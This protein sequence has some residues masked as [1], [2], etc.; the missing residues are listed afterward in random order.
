MRRFSAGMRTIVA[1]L[2]TSVLIALEKGTP[3][4]AVATLLAYSAWSGI[5]LWSEARGRPF[6]HSL[7]CYW[8]DVA[9]TVLTLKLATG[10][11]MLVLA[12]VHPVV[13]ASI[14][15]G[16]RHGAMLAL[17]AAL[18]FLFDM[19]E[20]L[21]TAARFD[22]ARATPMLAVLALTPAAAMLARPFTLVR[23]RLR[24]IDDVQPDLDP[25]RGLQATCS[26]AAES[27]RR[28]MNA[29]L[30]SL[31]LPSKSGGPAV[32]ATAEEGRFQVGVQVQ[33]RLEALLTEVPGEPVTHL[34][35]HWLHP[36]PHTR[37]HD[38][39]A[40][41]AALA[42]Q[43]DAL[44]ELLEVRMLHVV[45]LQRYGKRHGHLL[46]GHAGVRMHG[47]DVSVL[48]GAVHELLRSIEQAA[49]VDQLQE[50]SASHER[51]RI[52]RD[53]HDSAIQPY[54]GL[55]YAVECL[56][57]RIAPDNPARADVVALADL[58]TSEVATL[59][60]LIAGLRTGNPKGDNALVPAVRRQVRRFG[61][62]FGV[63]VELE[64]PDTL[65]TTRTLAA[66]LF[67]MVN[68]A[69]NNVRK[70]TEARHVRIELAAQDGDVRLVVR[71]DGGSVRGRPME[72][73]EPRS[74]CERVAELGGSL[75]IARPDGLNTE[76]KITIPL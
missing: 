33:E 44:A 59:R 56:A 75:A 8:I 31:L 73:F 29:R 34:R 54:L 58:V 2:T 7:L 40:P 11:A 61:Q 24:L 47:H 65:P 43:L 15:Y 74:L 71:D 14:G 4:L 64:C 66:A 67:H 26:T 57:L 36:R 35:A 20:Q 17:V 10:T 19:S 50:E 53:L 37:I 21:T 22:W 13:L 12:A 25:R 69:L 45:P 28:R 49:L 70:H 3:P 42:E 68:E 46:V 48:S 60:E 5:V 76:L 32:F 41:S 18:G 9:W 72:D 62:L 55:K 23:E 16:V 38:G 1:L 63:D 39:S 27:L 6:A 51:A 30:V 52:G